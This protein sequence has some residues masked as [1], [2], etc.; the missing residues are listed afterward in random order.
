MNRK[1]V[2]QGRHV[3]ALL[4]RGA[5]ILEE[6]FPDILRDLRAEGS[7][8]MD[9]SLDSVLY[10]N[11]IWKSRYSS[12]FMFHLQSRPFLEAMIRRRVRAIPQIAVLEGATVT[13][14]TATPDNKRVTGVVIERE[15]G[16]E[17]IVADLVVEADGR[18]TRAPQWLKDLGYGET[19]IST[20]KIDLAYASAIFEPPAESPPDWKM[21]AVVP[22]APARRHGLITEIEGGR[23]LVTQWGYFGDHPPLDPDG[24]QAFARSLPVPQLYDAISSATQVTPLVL[25]KV[26][27]QLRRHYERLE[28][29]PEGL[30]IIGDA[31]CSFNPIYG[32]GMTT[33]ALE[34][35]ELSTALKSR[36]AESFAT[37]TPTLQ[38]RMGKVVDS[39]W[40]MAT[41]SDMAYPQVEGV[42]P[43]GSGLIAKY[44]QRLTDIA[45]QDPVLNETFLQ[46][47]H[48]LKPATA[49]FQPKVVARVL[50]GPRPRALQEAPIRRPKSREMNA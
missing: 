16:E 22:A 6:L 28:R 19:P 20:L 12:G 40:Q 50:F 24:F 44:S 4:V 23:W 10:Q 43:F 18:G 17:T 13:R 3:H 30:V 36:G 11:G 39:P 21:L 27:H 25:H 29:F 32:Q 48:M 49:L 8:H 45:A 42:R 9:G 41:S 34:A 7:V 2:P 31:L 37:Y 35:I 15:S 26:P 1:G 47:I 14:L 46:V 38:K 5:Q 33:T